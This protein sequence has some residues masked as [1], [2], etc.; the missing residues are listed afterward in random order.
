[1]LVANL[2]N[3]GSRKKAV[4]QIPDLTKAYQ[5]ITIK[6]IQSK[7]LGE[8]RN[9]LKLVKKEDA[10]NLVPKTYKET[11]EVIVKA[12]DYLTESQ[13]QIREIF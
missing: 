6:T 11:E 10:K 8:A 4:E 9:N 7:Y 3:R 1:M 2:E 5:N 13:K 12:Q